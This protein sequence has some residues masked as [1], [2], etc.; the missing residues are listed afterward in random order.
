MHRGK[1]EDVTQF[2]LS[3]SRGGVPLAPIPKGAKAEKVKPW[4]GKDEELPV[5]E[6]L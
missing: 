2:P 5:E 6:E 1:F 3:L 4:D